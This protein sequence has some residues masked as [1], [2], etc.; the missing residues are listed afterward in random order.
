MPGTPASGRGIDRC[1][2]GRGYDV[3]LEGARVGGSPVGVEDAGFPRGPI[4]SHA[5]IA[6]RE[7]VPA[8]GGRAQ[9]ERG[10]RTGA[11]PRCSKSRPPSSATAASVSHPISL[12][13][14][15]ALPSRHSGPCLVPDPLEHGPE[16]AERGRREERRSYSEGAFRFVAGRDAKVGRG[17][18][19][20][21]EGRRLTAER[22]LHLPSDDN[23][24]AP[25]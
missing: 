15:C 16:C 17:H 12:A 10:Q 20:S 3:P 4:R 24:I 9:R 5:P 6:G 18:R 14:S 23:Y 1:D 25:S 8:A 19:A 11:G 21:G 7:A 13:L 2:V 22:Q